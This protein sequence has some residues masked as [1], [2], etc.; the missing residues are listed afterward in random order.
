MY[1]W[2]YSVFCIVWF[3]GGYRYFRVT[4]FLCLQDRKWRQTG[5]C[6]IIILN[7]MSN[8]VII[9]V[10]A[11]RGTGQP[12]SAIR[13]SLLTNFMTFYHVSSLIFVA[14]VLHIPLIFPQ[15]T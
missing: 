1:S 13:Q 3:Q 15:Y 7:L 8:I 5:S 14:H 6:E 9:F 2:L 10:I 12:Q 11:K 4:C